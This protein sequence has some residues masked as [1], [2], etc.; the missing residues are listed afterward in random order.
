LAFPVPDYHS[1]ADSDKVMFYCGRNYEAR[2][3]RP[4]DSRVRI[5]VLLNRRAS[6]MSLRA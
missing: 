1:N 3:G 5:I 4:T 6:P 2:K